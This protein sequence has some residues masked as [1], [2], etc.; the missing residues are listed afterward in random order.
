MSNVKLGVLKVTKSKGGRQFWGEGVTP[1]QEEGDP[2][3]VAPS[4]PP[5]VRGL[6]N[7]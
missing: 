3:V 6:Q 5:A 7:S 4:V 2:G 1:V